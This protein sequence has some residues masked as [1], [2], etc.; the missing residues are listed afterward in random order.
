MGSGRVSRSTLPRA[1]AAV[2]LYFSY[3]ERLAAA[4]PIA[5]TVRAVA[6]ATYRLLLVATDLSLP[7]RETSC[8]LTSPATRRRVS[9][10][11]R[12]CLCGCGG[13]SSVVGCR[14]LEAPGFKLVTATGDNSPKLLF[15]ASRR[16]RPAKVVYCANLNGYTCLS[17]TTIPSE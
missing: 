13:R 6:V 12:R 15:Q 11:V 14:H 8:P 3:R 7:A 2:A 17:S 1:L 4:F 10:L 5:F 9:F 16:G